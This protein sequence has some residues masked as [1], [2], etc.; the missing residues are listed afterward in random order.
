MLS[1]SFRDIETSRVIAGAGDTSHDLW[2]FG[3][4]QVFSAIRLLLEHGRGHS[5]A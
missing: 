3:I 4:Y 1:S 2:E 5:S